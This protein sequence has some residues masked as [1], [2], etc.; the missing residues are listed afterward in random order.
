MRPFTVRPH[1]VLAHIIEVE[2]ERVVVLVLGETEPDDPDRVIGDLEHIMHP[3]ETLFGVSFQ[4]YL[5]N[6]VG[7]LE[8][9]RESD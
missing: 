9:S 2:P 1:P 8:I 3:G 5:D 6:G 4:T 7:E